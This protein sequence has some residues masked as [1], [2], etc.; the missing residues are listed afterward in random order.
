MSQN[1]EVIEA[2]PKDLEGI[3]LLLKQRSLH[4]DEKVWQQY[5]KTMVASELRR[6]AGAVPKETSLIVIDKIGVV[7]GFCIVR[8]R[9]H[10]NY[11]RLLD[12][13]VIAVER[14]PNE[15]AIARTIFD[16]LLHFAQCQHFNALRF[17]CSTSKSWEERTAP[18]GDTRL[19]GTIMP[20]NID[21]Q[22]QCEPSKLSN[23][24]SPIP[25]QSGGRSFDQS[26]SY[27]TDVGWSPRW[28][29]RASA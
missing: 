12:A 22:G 26:R 20:L 28:Y 6:T 27:R 1:F 13:P 3:S 11:P 10:P 16:H 25:Q 8:R 4:P 2:D 9:R 7:R 18:D 23:A 29:S 14:G 21:R 5:C 17:G 24:G 15:N 19:G